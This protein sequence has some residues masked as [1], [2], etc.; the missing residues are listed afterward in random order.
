VLEDVIV[1]VHGGP[2]SMPDDASY[3]DCSKSGG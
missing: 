2:V 3:R 1:L